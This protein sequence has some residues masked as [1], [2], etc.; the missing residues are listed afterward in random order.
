MDQKK[1]LYITHIKAT[2][3][4]KDTSFLKEKYSITELKFHKKR[5]SEIPFLFLK[6]A[7]WLTFNFYKF[8]LVLCQFAGYHSF[9]PT[10]FAKIF[11]KPVLIVA[12]GTDSYNFPSIDYGNFRKL[13]L[14]YTTRKTYEWSTCIS[15]VDESLILS[16]SDY[17]NVDFDKQGITFFC[18]NVKARFE[19][20]YNGYDTSIFKKKTVVKKPNTF[21][22][23]GKNTE[24]KPVFLRKGIDLILEVA[25]KMP[26]C[27]FLIIGMDDKTKMP[28][29]PSNVRYIEFVSQDILAELLNET[30]F[31]LQLS[32]AE[33]FPN[34]LCEAMLCECVPIGSNVA[35]IPKIVGNIDLLLKKRDVTQLE[36]L[37]KKALTLD[38]DTLGKVAQNHIINE[39]SLE[40]RKHAFYK[41]IDSL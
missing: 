41:L 32:I 15:P 11:R 17:Y 26:E 31:Y 7:I 37:L 40:K 36:K 35:G 34:A 1:I 22:T 27:S 10:L 21:I 5:N 9:L 30:R 3:I 6:Q 33:G 13:F 12:C 18:P 8:D 20:I 29:A 39:F 2:F 24:R 23:I 16:S 14:G 19:T 38:L 25:K 4:E 28:V